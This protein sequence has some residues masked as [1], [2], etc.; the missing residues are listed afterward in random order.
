MHFRTL[1]TVDIPPVEEDQTLNEEISKAIEVLKAERKTGKKDF[2]QELA[3][4]SLYGKTSSFARSILQ[5]VYTLMIPYS[6]EPPEE[7]LEFDDRTDMLRAE[8][9][10]SVDCLKL[11]NGKIVELDSY[12]YYRKYC[13]KDGKVYQKDAGSLHHEKRTKKAKRM[14]ALPNYPRA[15]VY[16]SFKAYAGDYRGYP[17]DEKQ[18]AY[19]YYRNPNAMWDWYQVGGRW[20][21]MFLIKSDCTEYSLGERSWGNVDYKPDAPEGYIWVTAA[22][23]KDI[24]WDVMRGWITKKMTAR[25]YRLEKMFAEG[26]LEDG[27]VGHIAEDGIICWGDYEYRKGESLEENLERCA[28]PKA[29]KYPFGVHDIVDADDWLAKDDCYLDAESGKYVPVDWRMQIDEYIDDLDEDSVL[30]GVDYHI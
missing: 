8:F 16:K 15:K 18:Q 17:F 23:K 5:E 11:P 21:A 19:G 25:F 26:Q 10:R 13:I 7:Y 30:V 29:W 6:T 24:C 9:E 3:L 1:V 12:P 4:C 2:M 22:R 28:I 20:P 14:T 27:Y